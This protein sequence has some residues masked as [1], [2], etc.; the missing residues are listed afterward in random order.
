MTEKKNFRNA[1]IFRADGKGVFM[2]V[3]NSAFRIGKVQINFIQYDTG[4]NKQQK[5]IDTFLD[6]D[7]ALLL[8]QDILTGKMSGLSK[9][10]KDLATE[11]GY[12]YASYIYQK[13]GGVHATTLA[14]RNQTRADGK[15]LGREF[16]I[17]PGSSQPW[18]LSAEQGPGKELEK[19]LIKMEKSEEIIRVPLDD[20]GL[21]KFALV[22][23]AHI[24]GYVSQQY[25]LAGEYGNVPKREHIEDLAK[26]LENKDIQSVLVN[27]V[28]NG[29]NKVKNQ[30]K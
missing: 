14:K 7:D 22:L 30:P 17:T 21:K 5:R 9:K 12:K 15:A 23:K 24:E 18:I 2:E 19:G 10:A 26:L 20:D 28:V 27:A 29:I 6:V 13:Q 3:L 11:K 8:C 4:T 1:Q 16:K 25:G